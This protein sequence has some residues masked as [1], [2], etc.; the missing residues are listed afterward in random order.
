L[1]TK[2]AGYENEGNTL[3]REL[4]TVDNG[5]F[6]AR[7]EEEFIDPLMMS[8]RS[9]WDKK[10]AKLGNLQKGR[11]YILDNISNIKQQIVCAENRIGEKSEKFSGLIASQVVETAKTQQLYEQ[12]AQKERRNPK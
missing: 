9:S 7:K 6:S 8:A 1:E 10:T 3:Y 2:L 11:K 5:I 4:E 12:Q